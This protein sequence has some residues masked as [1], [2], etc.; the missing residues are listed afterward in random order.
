MK[1]VLTIA[2]AMLMLLALCFA[3]A[4]ELYPDTVVYTMYQDSVSGRAV[5]TLAEMPGGPV[6]GMIQWSSSANENTRWYFE[7]EG[8]GNGEEPVS[9]VNGMRVNDVY[10][11]A[12]YVA[13]VNVSYDNG[14]G[15]LIPAE[16]GGWLWQD[17][18]E[19]A[20]KDC[21][22]EQTG[23]SYYTARYEDSTGGRASMMMF[24]DVTEEENV[25]KIE[26]EWGNSAFETRVW[27]MTVKMPALKDTLENGVSE[28]AYSDCLCS[29]IA[30]GDKG[31]YTENT[32]YENGSGR[33]VPYT[34]EDGTQGYEWF[35]DNGEDGHCVF[36]QTM[37][38]A[39]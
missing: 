35:S 12:G 18:M 33:F 22:F 23:S 17:D 34:A 6:R 10:D 2:A 4:E 9:Y 15:R 32:V 28:L 8:S 27:Q 3:S 26:I 30:Y 5:L 1:K 7:L 24:G 39:E 25:V 21:R 16:N 19:D 11:E 13:D 36:M 37:I 38:P 14:T 31:D 20:G 29:D